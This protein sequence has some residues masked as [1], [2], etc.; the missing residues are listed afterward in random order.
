MI[1]NEE[2]L[3]VL[4]AKTDVNFL[5]EHHVFENICVDSREA[6]SGDLFVALHGENVDGHK[7]VKSALQNGASIALVDQDVEDVDQ[8]KLIKVQSTLQGLVDLAKYNVN[9]TKALYLG[10]TGSIG[11]TTTKNLIHHLLSKAT[12]KKTYVSQKNFNSQIGLPICAATMPADAEIGIFEMGMSEPGELKKLISVVSPKISVIS[13]VCETHSEFFNSVWDIAKAKSEI[14][15]TNE[16]Q[17]YAILPADC[18]YTSWLIEKAKKCGVRNVLTFGFSKSDAQV[19]SFS[20]ENDRTFV[21][22][23][24]LGQQVE[25][26][27]SCHNESV[28]PNSLSSILAAHLASGVSIQEIASHVKTFQAATRR[29]EIFTKGDIVIV[30]DSYNACATSMRSAIVSLA[31]YSGRKVLVVG[32]MKELGKDSKHYHANLSAAIDKFG[33]DV[34]FAC[35]ELAKYLFNNLQEHKKGLWCEN[36]EELSKKIIEFIKPEDKI[37]VKGSCSM[38]MNKVVEAI[39]N[40]L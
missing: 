19:I 22:A 6:K 20:H 11:K 10:V 16:P 31:K 29:G 38:N 7:F 4:N 33:I 28:I 27:I 26:E 14:L 24:I 21:T 30:D 13:H 40:V 36:S 9:Q 15:E 34:V 32:D 2:I 1:I 5:K 23:C 12:S 35:G 8:S 39:Y 37:L 17:E 25:Y 3:K 18:A